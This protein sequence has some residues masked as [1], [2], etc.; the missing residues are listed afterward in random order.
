MFKNDYHPARPFTHPV[1]TSG[2]SLTGHFFLLQLLRVPLGSFHW[3]LALST[4]KGP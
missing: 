2:A 3:A 4:T 1:E